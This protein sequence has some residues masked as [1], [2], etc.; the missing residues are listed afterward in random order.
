VISTRTGGQ[1]EESGAF[2][3]YD[4]IDL[5]AHSEAGSGSDVMVTRGSDGLAIRRQ[6]EGSSQFTTLARLPA[7]ADPLQVDAAVHLLDERPR[8][9]GAPL[10]P[11]HE[12]AGVAVGVGLLAAL[13]LPFILMRL[14]RRS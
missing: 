7:N 2:L 14:R 6:T 10:D 12:A 5:V 13:A 3:G 9:A 4:E 1:P 11:S 8:S